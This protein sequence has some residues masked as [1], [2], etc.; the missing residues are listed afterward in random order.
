MSAILWIGL[1]AVGGWF[2]WYMRRV[3][4]QWDAG[5][6]RIT[7]LGQR[8]RQLQG[9]LAGER[10]TLERLASDTKAAK[11]Q[12]ETARRDEKAVRQQQRDTV[13]PRPI[14]ILV[15]LEFSASSKD[16]PWLIRLTQRFNTPFQP[17]SQPPRP[18]LIWA[19]G[20]HS[21]MSRARQIAGEHQLAIHSLSRF[22]GDEPQTVTI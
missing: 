2:T 8:L 19:S 18:V 13:P 21:A 3:Q 15:P 7:A 11:R 17:P 9:E 4:L 20:D 22:G 12:A 6:D 10:Q 1:A 5:Q 16:T 14:E